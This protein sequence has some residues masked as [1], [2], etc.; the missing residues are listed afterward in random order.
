MC[1]TIAQG[2]QIR[3]LNT[4]YLGSAVVLG[5]PLASV[6]RSSRV[7]MFQEINR[8][9]PTAYVRPGLRGSESAPLYYYWHYTRPEDQGENYTNSHGNTSK[10]RGGGNIAYADGHVEY[11]LIKTVLAGDFGLQPPEDDISASVNK[12]YE[13]T[14]DPK[15]N[16]Q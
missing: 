7:A 14:N 16:F 6:Q 1:P 15:G 4:T 5:R 3:A 9:S 12:D 2:K 13:F 8:K 10:N 11:R